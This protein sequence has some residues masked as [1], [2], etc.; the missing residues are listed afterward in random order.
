MDQPHRVQ[1]CQWAEPSLFLQFP[2]WLASEDCP[3]SC[4]RSLPPRALD[5]AAACATCPFWKA[6][7]TA[8][9]RAAGNTS[10]AT[11]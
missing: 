5:T 8:G 4:L 2:H 11:P 10:G 7:G 1:S 9:N 3:W 6:R